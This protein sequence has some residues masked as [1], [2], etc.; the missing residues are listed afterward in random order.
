MVEPGQRLVADDGGGVARELP[1]MA[2]IHP[3]KEGE[4]G[5]RRE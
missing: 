2:D 3:A 4:W 1:G 5:G